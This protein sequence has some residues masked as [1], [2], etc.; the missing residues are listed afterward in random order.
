MK[1]SIIEVRDM[2]SALGVPGVEKR[3]G[4]V[5]GVESVTVNHAAGTTAVRYDETR[6]QIAD[7]KSDVRHAGLE[8]A[9]P[10][11]ATPLTAAP[12][13]AI[14]PGPSP[15]A[16][17]SAGS[18]GTAQ[19]DNASLATA[20]EP[21]APRP[22]PPAAPPVA[23]SA[24]ATARAPGLPAAKGSLVLALDDVSATLPRVGGKGASL[25]CMARAGFPVPPGFLIITESY[26]AFI[27]ANAL[28]VPIVALA[29]DAT[30]SSEDTSK[31]IRELFGPA[32]IPAVR[33]NI[34]P[35][36]RP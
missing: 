1:T 14:A 19:K 31:A 17:A 35:S 32:G 21:A 11:R 8:S 9:E 26:R 13:P 16:P 15:V 29:K 2:L 18:Q 10:D 34:A 3:I 36:F 12:T 6:L 20:P 23:A 28:Q 24:A 25:A 4:D 30:R 33:P 27:D 22:K 7:I 5:P